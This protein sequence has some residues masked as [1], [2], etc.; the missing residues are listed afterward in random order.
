[1]RFLLFLTFSLVSTSI[2]GQSWKPSDYIRYD[3]KTFPSSSMANTQIDYDNPDVALLNAAVFYASNA[4]R[5]RY[6]RRPFEHSYALEK[7]AYEHADDM[8]RLDFFSHTSPV[9][10]KSSMVD[11]MKAQGIILRAV[12]ENL[13]LNHSSSGETYLTLARRF[14]Q[15]WI[16]S[17]SHRKN[18]LNADY[19]YL[20]CGVAYDAKTKNDV[21]KY[22]RAAQNLSATTA[23]TTPP[24]YGNDAPE[25]YDVA[26]PLG[27]SQLK[28][29]RYLIMAGGDFSKR[30]NAQDAVTQLRSSGYPR[31]KV[32]SLDRV[33]T[34]SLTEFSD[35]GQAERALQTAKLK[36]TSAWIL[37]LGGK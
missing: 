4:A 19:K 25:S 7:A 36:F 20:G 1:M 34:V 29:N 35:L 15:Q 12:S 9:N 33:Y 2:L 28:K 27:L 14:V 17:P 21:Y 30:D 16:D 26:I 23:E 3:Y 18:L 22:F 11:R 24:T 31:A 5:V 13:A 37:R 8:V 10:G 6:G 32:V